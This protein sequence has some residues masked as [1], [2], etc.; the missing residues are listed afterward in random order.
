MLEPDKLEHCVDSCGTNALD[1]LLENCN[2]FYLA[3]HAVNK[4]LFLFFFLMASMLCGVLQD[5]VI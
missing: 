4:F 2:F 5:W 3:A 1:P